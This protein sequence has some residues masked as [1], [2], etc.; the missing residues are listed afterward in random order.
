M[1]HCCLRRS[2]GPYDARLAG[3]SRLFCGQPRH[4]LLLHEARVG[5]HR[6]V[7]PLRPQRLLV[8]GRDFHGGHHLCRRHAAGRYRPHL[9]PGHRRQL[10]VVVVPALRDAHRLLLRPAVAPRPRA[11]GHGVRRA[12]LLRPAR[13]LPAR[14]SRRVPGL[15]RQHHHHGLGEPGHGKDP[16]P[17]PWP[18]H[19]PPAAHR[20][21][22]LPRSHPGIQRHLRHV[23]CALD[24]P[25]PVR[26]E[27]E[28]GDP[29]R[30]L[31]RPRRGRNALARRWRPRLRRRS[32][33]QRPAARHARLHPCHRV[34]LLP[35]LPR[36]DLAELVG[37][38]VPR[39]RAR[40]RRLHRPAHL[41]RKE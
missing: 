9:Q 26:P 4:R 20:G 33:R 28:H 30:V 21:L 5:Q 14:L 16:C 34:T 23:G 22:L 29:A 11:D 31:C 3:D 32:P 12:P 41:F 18:H 35:E 40:R 24:G 39:G 36:P 10:A 7:L 37:E 13:H 38:L 8:A 17:D 27:D 1:E 2:D 25:G 19:H 15:P 6:R